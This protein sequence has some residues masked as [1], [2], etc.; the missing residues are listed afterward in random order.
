MAIKGFIFDFDGL[1]LDTET[2]E[3]DVW[4]EIFQT[5]GMHLPL[6]EW[7]AALGASFA[8]FDPVDLSFQ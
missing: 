1:I 8:A 2:P 7:Q 5:Y 6:N 3:F 4:Q